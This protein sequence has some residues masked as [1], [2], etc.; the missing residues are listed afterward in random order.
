MSS[1]YRSHHRRRDSRERSPS[2]AATRGNRSRS[3]EQTCSRRTRWDSSRGKYNSNERESSRDH[4]R[5]YH[6][7]SYEQNR[8]A[9]QS[10]RPPGN[11]FGGRDPRFGRDRRGGGGQIDPEFLAERQRQRDAKQFSI[12]PP[13]PTESADEEDRLEE[14]KII[15]RMQGRFD[16]NAG[17]TS[18][19]SDAPSDASAESE[20]RSS[21][22]SR[23]KKRS[24]RSRHHSSSKHDRKR[25]SSS[26]KHRSRKERDSSHRHRRHESDSSDEEHS[27]S[28]YS[29][30]RASDSHRRERSASISHEAPVEASSKPAA[31]EETMEQEIGPLPSQEQTAAALTEGDFGK[32]LL[33]GEGSAMAAFVQADQRIPRRG[34]VGMDQNMIERLENS[35]YVMSGNRHRRMNAVRVRKENQVVS[36]EEKRQM[37]L[38][39]QEERLK[40]EAQVIASFREML[41]K[42]K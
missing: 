4:R 9:H 30:D 10:T 19:E 17:S 42:K 20:R 35:G 14:A 1:S 12:W 27:L 13:S 32:A 40:K 25:K 11:E 29:S 18:G 21:A 28:A 26:S 22:R 16:D 38:Q 36:A 31:H 41:S 23:K 33:P 3:R 24:S 5:D 6:S 39:N 2:P 8:G 7:R 15:A 37:L 34:E